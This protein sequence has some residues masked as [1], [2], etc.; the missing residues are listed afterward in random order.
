M[1][2]NIFFQLVYLLLRLI[3]SRMI[4]FTMQPAKNSLVLEGK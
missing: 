2:N 3:I 4:S 1:L